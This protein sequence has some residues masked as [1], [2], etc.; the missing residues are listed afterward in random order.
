LE[1]LL[2]DR[3]FAVLPDGT[4]SIA[5]ARWEPPH[6]DAS[7][8]DRIQEEITRR[9]VATGK[10][11][12]ST[13]RHAERLWLRFNLVNLYTREEHIYCLV[14]LLSESAREAEANLV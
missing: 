1:R 6:F 12:F 2:V 10:A 7:Q 11:W 5:C 13:V 9:V 14:D 8:F 4:L 3:G